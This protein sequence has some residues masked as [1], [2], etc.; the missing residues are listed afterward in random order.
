MMRCSTAELN[1]PH[2]PSRLVLMGVTCFKNLPNLEIR[3]KWQVRTIVNGIL[4]LQTVASFEKNEYSKRAISASTQLTVYTGSS[5]VVS[6]L[7]NF[8]CRDILPDAYN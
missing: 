2:L 7:C 5:H 8:V 1:S 6:L 3:L 4:I